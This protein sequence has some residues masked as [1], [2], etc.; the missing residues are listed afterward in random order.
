MEFCYG[1]KLPHWRNDGVIY[2]VTWRLA[3]RRR[4]LDSC[5]RDLAV[6]VLKS[7]EGQHYQLA[8]YAVM[9]DHVHAL[10]TQLAPYGLRG[11]LHFW[12]SFTARQMQRERKRFGRV[13]QDE[14]FD[15]IVRDENALVLKLDYIR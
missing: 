14:C 9:D 13:W 6:A 11:T 8:A 10:V 7:F 3:R 4:E 2:F 15:R 12:K 5:E 1:R